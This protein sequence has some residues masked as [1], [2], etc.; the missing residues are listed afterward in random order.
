MY[1]CFRC[2]REKIV[3]G[4][5]RKAD[6]SW[7][8]DA[9]LPREAKGKWFCCFNCYDKTLREEEAKRDEQSSKSK[10]L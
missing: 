5:G 2:G 6:G 10:E 9:D 7:A 1:R 3:F 4:E 8:A